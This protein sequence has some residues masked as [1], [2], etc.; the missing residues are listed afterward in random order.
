[1]VQNL[2]AELKEDIKVEADYVRVEPHDS[3]PDSKKYNAL[4]SRIDFFEKRISSQEKGTYSVLKTGAKPTRTVRIRIHLHA[5]N[6]SKPVYRISTKY[7]AKPAVKMMR[8]ELDPSTGGKVSTQKMSS[9]LQ[10]TFRMKM[11]FNDGLDRMRKVLGLSGR[12]YRSWPNNR[13]CHYKW[14]Q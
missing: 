12:Y 9:G 8:T 13:G 2:L 5:V 11:A 14:V 7:A 1:M 6:D 10:K 3:K 4:K